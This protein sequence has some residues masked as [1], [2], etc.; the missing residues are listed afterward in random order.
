M[1]QQ[2]IHTAFLITLFT[3]GCIYR[4]TNINI[5]DTL[6]DMEMVEKDIKEP[7]PLPNIQFSKFHSLNEAFSAIC[8]N[9]HPAAT[10]TLYELT[11]Y[12]MNDHFVIF[13]IDANSSK[14]NADERP[15]K[16][17]GDYKDKYY[18]I[19]DSEFRD[20]DWLVVIPAIRNRFSD[21][22][23]TT[24]FKKSELA[25]LKPLRIQFNDSIDLTIN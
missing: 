2:L 13:F 14:K 12:K 9:E 21:F 4:Q 17:G 6:P 10:D 23:K 3:T 20:K 5:S 7:A 22:S 24:E 1:K 8:T 19:L 18:Q 15:S 11:L 25:K 16:N